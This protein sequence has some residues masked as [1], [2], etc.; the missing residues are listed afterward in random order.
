[1]AAEKQLREP[2]EGEVEAPVAPHFGMA[3]GAGVVVEASPGVAVVVA[4]AEHEAAAEDGDGPSNRIVAPGE[5]R[6]AMSLE[7]RA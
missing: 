4:V 5:Q 3:A 7:A 1:M 6:S 2:P